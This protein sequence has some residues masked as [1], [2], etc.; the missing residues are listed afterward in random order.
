MQLAFDKEII[1]YLNVPILIASKVEI[2]GKLVVAKDFYRDTDEVNDLIISYYTEVFAKN[3]MLILTEPTNLNNR[4]LPYRITSLDKLV[5]MNKI[6]IIKEVVC[7]VSDIY[8]LLKLSIKPNLIFFSGNNQNHK[9]INL[10]GIASNIGFDYSSAFSGCIIIVNGTVVLDGGKNNRMLKLT[11]TRIKYHDV[12][13][14]CDS[15]FY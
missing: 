7:D 10:N 2:E 8:L 12:E 14:C 3:N 1:S 5:P 4:P 11:M 9:L 6:T 13:I 15:L